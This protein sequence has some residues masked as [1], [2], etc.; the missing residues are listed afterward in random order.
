M[1]AG[2]C[3]GPP[4]PKDYIMSLTIEYW[5]LFPISILIPTIAIAS[6]IGGAMFM[7]TKVV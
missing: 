3:A 2:R 1:G 7:L 5:Y 4:Q 6:G